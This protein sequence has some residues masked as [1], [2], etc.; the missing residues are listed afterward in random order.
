MS[1]IFAMGKIK[2]H[3]CKQANLSKEQAASVMDALTDCILDALKNGQHVY[4]DLG[5]FK[6]VTRAERKTRHPK[7]GEPVTIP[8]HKV[9]KFAPSK[10]V[11]ALW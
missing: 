10:R 7:T 2:K 3:L 8:A 11:K 9:L 6:V 1:D 4:T 5:V